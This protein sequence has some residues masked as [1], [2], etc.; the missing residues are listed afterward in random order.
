MYVTVFTTNFLNILSN[1]Y[2]HPCLQ[3]YLEYRFQTPSSV[4]VDTAIT[5]ARFDLPDY[6]KLNLFNQNKK[7]LTTE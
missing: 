3:I 7:D 2:T 4:V 6:L 1:S 5:L